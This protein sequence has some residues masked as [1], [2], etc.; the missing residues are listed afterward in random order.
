[1]DDREGVVLLLDELTF[2]PQVMRMP[3]AFVPPLVRRLLSVILLA[4][5][6]HNVHGQTEISHYT[7]DAPRGK[8][9]IRILHYPAPGLESDLARPSIL[10][11]HGG[12]WR[13]GH[14]EDLDR[15]AH[16]LSKEGFEVFLVGHRRA[17]DGRTVEHTVED[18][19][20]AGTWLAERLDKLNL[21]PAR[22]H[23]LGESSGGHL[24]ACLALLS[25]SEFGSKGLLPT[26]AGLAL[27]NPIVDLGKLSWLDNQIAPASKRARL[28]PVQG[29][30]E[31]FA[32][33]TLIIHG[34]QDT[35]APVESIRAFARK[36]AELQVPV[37]VDWLR[38]A[39]HAFV[40]EAQTGDRAL[41]K[42]G[43]E[44]LARTVAFWR[45]L[46]PINFQIDSDSG[47]TLE[48]LHR[49]KEA[50]GHQPF[51]SP[52]YHEGILYGATHIGGRH[53]VGS[54]YRID[55]DGNNF[56]VIDHFDRKNGHEAFGDLTILGDRLFGV[57]KFGGAHRHGTLYSV[58]LTDEND[59]SGLRT[60]H[61]FAH[62][63]DN[64]WGSNGPITIGGSKLY[65]TAF[66]GGTSQW[67]GGIW[68]FDTEAGSFEVIA[69]LSPHSSQHPTGALIWHDGWLW[70]T[71]SGY[72]RADEGDFG[73]V[74]RLR[75]DGKDF[76]IVHRFKG[77]S[78]GA[79]PYDALRAGPDGWLW[80]TTFGAFDAPDDPGT[81]F[82]LNP[83]SK[84]LEIVID[85]S[86]IPEAGAKPNGTLLFLDDGRGFFTTHG[87]DTRGGTVPGTL[88][89]WIP[90]DSKE[91]N[92]KLN[93][94]QLF[95]QEALEHGLTPMRN[96]A[97]DGEFLYGI[98]AFGGIDYGGELGP[99]N[100]PRS[101]GTLYRLPIPAR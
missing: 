8:Q 63:T 79:H 37:R 90:S 84:V 52:L 17:R 80:G 69:N 33:P 85:F 9:P 3:P 57:T 60:H 1:M 88:L 82:R 50:E 21:D 32:I 87:N 65:G 27:W 77:G 81:V 38:G 58:H 41:S 68:K 92:G 39:G 12:G 75:P 28:S 55:I 40:H 24:A 20:H 29:L 2:R 83:A 100:L 66:H 26:W 59:T 14:P 18:A 56:R 30:N 64:L 11:F 46:H 10:M 53:K 6:L 31:A 47:Q 72:E 71:T 86:K 101:G 22:V 49:F 51:T 43:R 54:V 93:R 44:T 16:A 35:V 67:S 42:K 25:P 36:A 97:T 74:F 62:A 7:I 76:E 34:D 48:V 73:S 19:F 5:S 78:L 96:L 95:S 89:E 98:T 91:G 45:A 13:D 4:G 15:H 23:L 99:H 94:L 61:H 70:G